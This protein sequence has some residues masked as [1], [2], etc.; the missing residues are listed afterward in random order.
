M[1]KIDDN[2]TAAA[3]NVSTALDD[4]ETTST[5]SE[6]T[7]KANQELFQEAQTRKLGLVNDDNETQNEEIVQQSIIISQEDAT[8]KASCDKTLRTTN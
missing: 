6:N 7:E 3:L 4:D 8:N 5:G 2:I 1:M